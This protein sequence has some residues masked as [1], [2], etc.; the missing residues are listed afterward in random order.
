[1]DQQGQHFHR[2]PSCGGL[3]FLICTSDDDLDCIVRQRSL[4]RLGLI[5]Q[6]AHPDVTLLIGH[7]DDRH[8]LRVNR[9]DDGVR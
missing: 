5:P 9:L 8:G 7:Q 3:V 1:M 4:Q 2:Y 6:R